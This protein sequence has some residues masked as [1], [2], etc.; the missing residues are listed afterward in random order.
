LNAATIDKALRQ[1]AIERINEVNRQEEL[2]QKDNLKK[3]EHKKPIYL[4][5]NNPKSPKEKIEESKDSTCFE[6]NKI[7]VDG[8]SKI[9]DKEIRALTYSDIN[10]C[11]SLG[12][13]NKIVK[14]IQELY[15][16]SGYITS[17][18]ILKRQNLGSKILKIFVIEG[19][20][21]RIIF[22]PKKSAKF[23]EKKSAFGDIEGDVLS[24]RDLEQ[25]LENL[26]TL[27]SNNA[28][29]DLKPS[30]KHGFTDVIIEN[31]K[32]FPVNGSISMDN[33]GSKSTSIYQGH[34]NLNTESLFGLNEL[35]SFTYDRD[36]AFNDA[37]NYNKTYGLFFSMPYAYNTFSYSISYSQNLYTA[38]RLYNTYS[39]GLNQILKL[40]RTL[41]RTKASKT[42]AH[43][44]IIYKDTK[45]Y[46][47][48]TLALEP[49]RTRYTFNSGINFNTPISLYLINLGLEYY[50]G[51]RNENDDEGNAYRDETSIE[52]KFQKILAT[53]N[54]TYSNRVKNIPI[55]ISSAL[56]YQYSNDIL[57]SGEQIGVGGLY[58][59]RGFLGG[60]IGEQGY[61]VRSSANF[62][63]RVYMLNV[64]PYTFYDFGAITKNIVNEEYQ[65]FLSGYG[66]G[67][68]VNHKYI[69]TDIF[70]SLP[71]MHPEKD[72]IDVRDRFILNFS[73]KINIKD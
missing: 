19:K 24:L 63:H 46:I 41:H 22:N 31:K 14:K 6:I 66:F 54:V 71:H 10:R 15:S 69:N 40:E 45:S 62:T 43:L 16:D 61:H 72:V 1:K 7:V 8:N 29:F 25:G 55:S 9:S 57:Y 5:N 4:Q 21:N 44:S 32:S 68:K 37:L 52:K 53:A 12:E 70:V 50:R 17:R 11:I 27:S 3:L 59:V 20:I 30:D 67:L 33:K 58:S 49:S 51:I 18:V 36:L 34:I 73:V 39:T 47:N 60:L 26:S 48:G 42:K 35:I 64:T 23:L 38:S 65:G 13:I 28:K 56:T 2:R